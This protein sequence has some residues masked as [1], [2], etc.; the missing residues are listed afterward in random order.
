MVLGAVKN[1]LT[2]G[3]GIE[4]MIII[5]WLCLGLILY[6]YLQALLL[7]KPELAVGPIGQS[8]LWL[9]VLYLISVFQVVIGTQMRSGLEHIQ[10]IFPLLAPAEWIEKLG[11][12]NQLHAILGFIVMVLAIYVTINLMR[13]RTGSMAYFKFIIF[14]IDTFLVLQIVVGFTLVQFGIPSILQILHLWF[15][16]LI[17][18]GL[19]ILIS[20]SK[21]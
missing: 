6:T 10:D 13:G 5:F 18:G 3:S 20:Y 1:D 17:I 8:K 21:V 4:P 19:L 2:E 9:I 15:S 16:S 12:V 11:P 14:A 7:E